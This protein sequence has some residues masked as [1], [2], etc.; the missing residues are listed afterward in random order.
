MKLF[1]YEA[2]DI[3]RKYGIRVPRGSVAGSPDEAALAAEQIGG[4]VALKAQ[5]L[6]SGRGKA[7]GIL[8]AQNP[9]EART[10][11]ARLLGSS[12]KGMT[13]DS[14]LVEEKLNLAEQYYAS[15]T[16]DRQARTPT[17]LSA[18]TDAYADALSL[19]F[20]EA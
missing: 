4:P 1:E 15:V 17:I 20:L 19:V 2:K 11:A 5:V 10:V 3:L 12:I 6:V 7:G 8:F 9:D 14:L 16:I 13:V 18:S